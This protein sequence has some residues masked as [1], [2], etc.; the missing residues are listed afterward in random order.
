QL[1]KQLAWKAEQG[2]LTLETR[3]RTSAIT[4]IA[5]FI[6]FTD[7]VSLEMPVNAAASENTLTTTASD[8]V[9]FM[10]DTSMDD[11]NWWLVGVAD[12]TDATAVDTGLAPEA[13]AWAVYRIELDTNGN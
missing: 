3:V 9:G 12:D 8:A 11:D 4:T 13:D 5:L 7:S 2:N 6:G 10:F 1:V